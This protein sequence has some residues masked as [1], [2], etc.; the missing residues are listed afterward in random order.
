MLDA[1]N[2][3]A[4]GRISLLTISCCAILDMT[5]GFELTQFIFGPYVNQAFYFQ[6]IFF[7]IPGGIYIASYV[8]FNMRLVLFV[9]RSQN[10]HL[11]GQLRVLKRKM[12]IFYTVYSK[13]IIYHSIGINR[14]YDLDVF[15]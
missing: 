7:I 1:P 4:A 14:L 11:A 9:W 10:L 12:L 13:F 6:N 5:H 2:F 15:H 8:L 3:V